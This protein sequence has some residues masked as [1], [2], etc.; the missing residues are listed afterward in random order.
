MTTLRGALSELQLA[1]ADAAA[2]PSDA[3]PSGPAEPTEQ[4]PPAPADPP[5]AGGRVAPERPR[6]WTPGGDV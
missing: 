4:P 6:I 3:P 2:P 1:Y 5:P